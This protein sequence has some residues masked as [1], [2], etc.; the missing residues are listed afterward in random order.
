M[1]KARILIAEDEPALRDVLR[2]QLELEGYEG[3]EAHDGKQALERAFRIL[4]ISFK[5]ADLRRAY[6]ALTS[7]DKRARANVSEFVD[8][9]LVRGDRKIRELVRIVTDD[10]DPVARARAAADW[11]EAPPRTYRQAVDVLK[12]DADATVAMIAEFHAGELGPAGRT[13]PPPPLPA[14]AEV[15]P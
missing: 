2:M 5:H 1:A 8:V 3:L 11:V 4:Q 6:V 9:L 12:R 15:T 14:P 7:G 10:L 13:E